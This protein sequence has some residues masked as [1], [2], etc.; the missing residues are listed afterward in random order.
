VIYAGI[1][2]GTGD[3]AIVGVS[4]VAVPPI[5]Q[6]NISDISQL[7]RDVAADRTDTSWQDF[8]ALLKSDSKI[9]S[10]PDRL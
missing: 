4:N 1:P 3:F 8:L 9:E 7:R 5:E 6:L 10:Y 2:I